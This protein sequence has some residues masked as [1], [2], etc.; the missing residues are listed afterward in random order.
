M[1]L[2]SG[3]GLGSKYYNAIETHKTWHDMGVAVRGPIVGDVNDHF[4]QVFNEARVN[5]AGLAASR[6]VPVPRLAYAD[7]RAPPPAAAAAGS[8][9][10][11]VLTTHP[12]R[13]D[14]S[15]RGIYVAALASAR[16]SIY[17]ENSFFSD[18]L[19]ARLLMH[20]A[21][22][23][24][25]RVHCAGL[26]VHECA[27]RR[28]E[29]VQ[30]YLVLPDTSDKP[31]VD[32]VGAADFHEML[33]LGIKVHRWNPT[34]GWSASRMLHSKVWLI[35][36]VPGEGGLTYVGAANATQRSHLAD[37]ESGILSTDPAFAREV[38]E[39]IFVADLE[40]ASRRESGE[41]F[42]VVRSSSSIVRGS[43]WLRRFLVDLLWL[44]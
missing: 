12:E 8:P 40:S 23:F 9:R 2:Q 32:A 19:V 35:D 44:I 1:A 27:A 6:G 29:A 34:R 33:H 13:G 25:S 15:Y 16:R 17:I 37:N 10:T 26:G 43:R 38:Y 36:Y 3:M 30:I 4:V 41:N 24:R 7:Y 22:E 21:R 14:S 20:K 28:R 11:W 42:H 31:I 5:N 18:P 39:R